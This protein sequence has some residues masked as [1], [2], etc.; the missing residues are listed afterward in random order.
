MAG[1]FGVEGSSGL[2]P[3]G[4]VLA[5]PLAPSRELSAVSPGFG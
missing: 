3:L 1:L 5:A 2:S 4:T